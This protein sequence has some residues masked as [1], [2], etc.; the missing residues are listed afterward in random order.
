[1]E[2]K[3]PLKYIVAGDKLFVRFDIG[4]GRLTWK[5]ALISCLN[6]KNNL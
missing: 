2:K 3:I 6:V 4:Q 5:D 1:M